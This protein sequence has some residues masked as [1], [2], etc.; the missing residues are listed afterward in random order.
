MARKRRFGVKPPTP[1]T[2]S[3]ESRVRPYGPRRIINLVGSSTSH[4]SHAIGRFQAKGTAVAVLDMLPDVYLRVSFE[5]SPSPSPPVLVPYTPLVPDTPSVQRVRGRRFGEGGATGTISIK[6]TFY[7]TRPQAPLLRP[8]IG[9]GI[10]PKRPF[11]FVALPTL[12]P[13]QAGVGSFK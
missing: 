5:R 4:L 9:L 7:P 3:E 8:S 6:G 13:S 2:T 10:R 12:M 11:S 1:P